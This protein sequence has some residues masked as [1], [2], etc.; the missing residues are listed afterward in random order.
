[1]AAQTRLSDDADSHSIINSVAVNS[2][3]AQQGVEGFPRLQDRAR[4]VAW[5]CAMEVISERMFGRTDM[6]G[7]ALALIGADLAI[8]SALGYL[9]GG[10]D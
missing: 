7:V 8:G 6:R 1:M 4:A 9:D 2:F 5:E 3:S 10:S